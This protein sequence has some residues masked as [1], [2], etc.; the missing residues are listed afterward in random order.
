ME[1]LTFTTER[2]RLRG[3]RASD[4]EPFAALNADPCVMRFF[5]EPLDRARSDAFAHRAQQK[6]IERGFGLWAVEA[7]GVTPFLGYLGLAQPVFS[8]HFTPCIEI[9]WRLTRR[10]WEHGYATEAAM[11][12]LDHAFGSLGLSEIVSFTAQDNQ[13]SRRVMERLGMRYRSSED[14]DHPNIPT[15][16]PLRRHVLYRLNRAQWTSSRTS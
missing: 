13:R 2:L 9:G 7:P 11:A 14:F 15:G 16:R 10:H 1:V 4:L 8:A 5:S 12:V 3:W 6:L